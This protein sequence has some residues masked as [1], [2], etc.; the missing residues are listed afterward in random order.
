MKVKIETEV[1]LDVNLMAKTFAN[2][3]SDE[4]AEF[5]AMAHNQLFA[6]C[7][8]AA[9]RDMQLCYV[10]D[11]IRREKT[12]ALEFF[13]TI[14]AFLSD[15]TPKGIVIQ[16]KEPTLSEL[17]DIKRY[18]EKKLA[19][20][21]TTSDGKATNKFLSLLNPYEGKCMGCNAD[22]GEE[23][24]PD[25]QTLTVNRLG[26][27]EAA[28]RER[29]K[30]LGELGATHVNVRPTPHWDSLVA[31]GLANDPRFKRGD[32]VKGPGPDGTVISGKLVRLTDDALATI[33]YGNPRQQQKWHRVHLK[34]LR[35]QNEEMPIAAGCVPA[36]PLRRQAADAL[37]KAI[38]A[39]P[40]DLGI[41]PRTL[42]PEMRDMLGLDAPC[43]KAVDCGLSQ[44]DLSTDKP[45]PCTE[46]KGTGYWDNPGSMTGM[47]Y[48]C[49]KGCKP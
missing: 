39:V 48:P 24:D 46:C 33:E 5:F 28:K 10:A 8:G 40:I 15:D 30:P 26:L 25:C 43:D 32:A 20:H 6:S 42:D 41:G 47:R 1:D 13:E 21:N 38:Q 35:M 44:D 45:T 18:A 16:G 22:K 19:G 17:L 27:G 12:L 49:S 29:A 7:N 4:Q 9:G 31:A 36:N 3:G 14:G 37:K 2:M 34:D 23:H 11:A